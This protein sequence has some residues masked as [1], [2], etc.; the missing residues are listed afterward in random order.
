MHKNKIM[1]KI[2]LLFLVCAFQIGFGQTIVYRNPADK[3]E[4]YFQIHL[5]QSPVKGL[6]V[7]AYEDFIDPTIATRQGL[8]VASLVPK[9]DYLLTMFDARILKKYEEMI[10]DICQKHQIPLT[11]VIV[12]GLSAGGVLAVRLGE[13]N[14]E[15]KR[16]WQPVAIFAIDPPLDYE[17]FWYECTRKV[18]LNFHPAAV[19]EGKEIMRRMK[20]A[21]GGSPLQAQK[22]YWS[23][24]PY[25]RNAPNGGRIQ[26]LKSVPIRIYHEPDIDWWIENR[27][28]DYLST[29]SIDCA[30]AINDLK[31]LGNT[32]AE[33]ISTTGKGYRADGTRHP[34]SWSIVNEAELVQWCLQWL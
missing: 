3:S 22:K 27:R 2:Q 14:I 23:L 13:N 30:G 11:K 18:K 19:A 4:D 28:Q 8:A 12:G 6:I 29:N 15:K 24:A 33:L 25:S 26:W 20:N 16:P 9:A 5:P 34:H 32:R 10:E 7:L 21:F 1:K 17:R 31:I